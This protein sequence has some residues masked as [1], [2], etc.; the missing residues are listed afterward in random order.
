VSGNSIFAP[1]G[2][3]AFQTSPT[4]TF[5]TA[6]APT[7]SSGNSSTYTC[8]EP[9]AAM[10]VGSQTITA[11]FLG[12]ANYQPTNLPTDTLTQVVVQASSTIKVTNAGS[13]SAGNPPRSGCR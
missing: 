2:P 6:A 7:S 11:Q 10:V 8:V 5:C 3:V 4:A 13:G 12:D 9:G 1:T